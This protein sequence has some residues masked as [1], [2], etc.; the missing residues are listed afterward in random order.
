MI[1]VTGGA[2]F[3]GSNL[4]GALSERGEEVVVSDRL[5]SGDKWRNLAKHELA[6]LVHPDRLLPWL[7]TRGTAV[8]ALLHMG[9]IS[10]TTETDADLIAETNIRLTMELWEWCA[11]A[12]V[13]FLYASSAATYGDG[14]RGFD[15][16]GSPE[17]LALLRP[18]NPYGWSKLVVDRRVA[19]LVERGGPRPPQWV[20][21]RF[22]NVY[23]P[24]EYHKGPMRS[25]AE[26]AFRR[27]AA[28]EPVRLFRSHRPDYADGG[29]LR[30]FVYVRD[31]VDLI[32]WLLHHPE[33]SGLFNCGSGRARSF[34]D[35]AGA[36]FA[37]LGAEPRIEW[38]DMPVEIRDR[39]QYFTEARMERLREAG[40]T[41]P[42]R[43]LEEGITE[44]VQRYLATGDP[45]R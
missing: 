19:R 38:I 34:L 36:V 26:Q 9:A 16:D 17:A 2:G 31:C 29:Q 18:L 27:A 24:N 42:F 37:A 32:L 7:R 12:G 1:V 10:S 28:G 6:D 33:V 45:Y 43:G 3:I 5:R 21:L 40:Y 22:F 30:D 4:V 8:T 25:V 15:D 39:Y 13:P 20:G 14:V 44:Y 11:A 23:G 35:L 41:A